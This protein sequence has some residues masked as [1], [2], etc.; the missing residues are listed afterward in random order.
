MRVRQSLLDKPAEVAV[1]LCLKCD[2]TFSFLEG[3]LKCPFCGAT[4]PDSLVPVYME[5]DKTEG[6]MYSEVDWYPGD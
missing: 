2:K 1:Y 6:D 5:D 3:E 4:D